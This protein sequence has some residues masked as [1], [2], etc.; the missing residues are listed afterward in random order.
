MPRYAIKCDEQQFIEKCRNTLKSLKGDDLLEFLEDVC[1]EKSDIDSMDFKTLMFDIVQLITFYNT[2]LNISADFKVDVD[3]ENYDF[4]RLHHFNG[5]TVGIFNNG[6]DWEL[7]L[8]MCFYFDKNNKIRVYVPSAAIYNKKTKN[9]FGNGD[10][11]DENII[12]NKQ[13]KSSYPNI[14]F[15]G[16]MRV[17]FGKIYDSE[18]YNKNINA[19]IEKRIEVV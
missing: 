18:E 12:F 10:E 19:D 6:G 11:D 15:D 3:G 13:Y 9:A 1:M 17:V 8:T 16:E 7:P 4:E 2:S 5:T 14:N